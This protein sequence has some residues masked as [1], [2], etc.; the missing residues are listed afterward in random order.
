MLFSLRVGRMFLVATAAAGLESPPMNR[1]PLFSL[2][3]LRADRRLAVLWLLLAGLLVRGL[4]APGFMPQ[5][6]PQGIAIV[7]CTP[8]GTKTVWQAD[9]AAGHSV[10]QDQNCSFALALG[11]PALPAL[12]SA[13]QFVAAAEAG[14]LPPVAAVPARPPVF[15]HGARGPPQL[16]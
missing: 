4:I 3:R 9:A 10:Q 11:M 6:G 16:S 13:L 8:T 1:E 14:A 7:L 15:A 12:P 5:I 2:H